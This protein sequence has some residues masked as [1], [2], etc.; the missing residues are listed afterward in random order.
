VTRRRDR[1]RRRR[2][3]LQAPAI[4]A[5]LPG[6]RVSYADAAAGA[7]DIP[8]PVQPIFHVPVLAKGIGQLV[9]PDLLPGQVGHGVD[10]LAVPA[11]AGRWAAVAQDLDLFSIRP[12]LPAER[13]GGSRRDHHC[14]HGRLARGE[15]PS[16]HHHRTA[17]SLSDHC[18]CCRGV[19]P[20][21]VGSL[22]GCSAGVLLRGWI[23]R[24]DRDVGLP[25]KSDHQRFISGDSG[26]RSA[27][28]HRAAVP[29]SVRSHLLSD[30]SGRSQ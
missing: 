3:A 8:D 1:S 5:A 16:D 30:G 15:T 23:G 21:A 29:G 24:V 13:A 18:R 11:A 17:A 6:S 14:T 27:R 4:G 2:G 26:D 12:D 25:G 19:L 7:G 10:G 9:G 28:S 20:V 22:G